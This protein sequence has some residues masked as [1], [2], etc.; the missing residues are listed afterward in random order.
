MSSG[1]IKMKKLTK[2]IILTFFIMC[3]AIGFSIVSSAAT[4]YESENND[5]IPKADCFALG[6]TVKGNITKTNADFFTFEISKSGYVNFKITVYA[7][8]YW[9]EGWFVLYDSNGEEVANG[10]TGYM[11]FDS[12]YGAIRDTHEYMLRPGKYYVE[13]S[14]SS[15]SSRNNTYDYTITSKFT[16]TSC[17]YTEVDDTLLQAHTVNIGNKIRGQIDTPFEKE[18]IKNYDYECDYYVFTLESKT[19]VYMD[20]NTIYR[21]SFSAYGKASCQVMDYETEDR[22]GDVLRDRDNQT[23]TLP[24]GKYFIMV[25]GDPRGLISYEITLKDNY[26]GFRKVNGKYYYYVDGEMVTGWRKITNKKGK[27]YQYYF[28][29]DGVMVTGWKKITNKKGKTYQ[30]YFKDDGVMKT[31]WLKLSGKWYYF[32]TDG[33]MLANCSKKIGNKTYKFNK[34]GVCLNP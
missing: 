24:A 6:N 22:I 23:I 15:I 3:I 7:Q 13:L 29:D 11:G 34:N 25:T 32:K 26:T 8:D 21:A 20:F 19:N 1:G 16:S 5:T 12:N 18:G 17:N 28:K 14:V 27:T 31:G 9:D 33:V 4:T 10:N 2:A 30:Y